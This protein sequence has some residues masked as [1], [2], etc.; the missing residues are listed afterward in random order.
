VGGPGSTV[1]LADAREPKI[2]YTLVLGV[3]PTIQLLGFF[4][5]EVLIKDLNQIPQQ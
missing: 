1:G 2:K 3:I 4:S 5:W